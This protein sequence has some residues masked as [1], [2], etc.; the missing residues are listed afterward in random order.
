MKKGIFR[1]PWKGLFSANLGLGTDLKITIEE[2]YY[3]SEDIKLI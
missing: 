3:E 2:A 1:P